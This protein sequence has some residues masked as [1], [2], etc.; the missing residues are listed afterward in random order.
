M[1]SPRYPAPSFRGAHPSPWAWPG[2]LPRLGGFPQGEVAGGPLLTQAVRG[3]AQIACGHEGGVTRR[4]QVVDP[5]QGRSRHRHR[6]P[7]EL[8][9]S[10]WS[11]PPSSSLPGVC[12]RRSANVYKALVTCSEVT[13]TRAVSR[14]PGAWPAPAFPPAP[15]VV[16]GGTAA[17]GMKQ[18]LVAAWGPRLAQRRLLAAAHRAL[19]CGSGR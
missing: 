2:W 5:A 14:Q 11:S 4:D 9:L 6:L 7:T 19:S 16:S 13:D 10:A 12:G 18:C 3:D 1:T 15:S 17:W 8:C